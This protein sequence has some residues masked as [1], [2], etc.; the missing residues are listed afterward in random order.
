MLEE[1]VLSQTRT[2]PV[3]LGPE[4]G[5]EAGDAPNAL[6]AFSA[7]VLGFRR[8]STTNEGSRQI[9]VTSGCPGTSG[10]GMV[11][12]AEAEVYPFRRAAT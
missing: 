9:P 7:S 8:T 12:D 10:F 2:A 6:A 4:A 11:A 1:Q 3:E 5:F